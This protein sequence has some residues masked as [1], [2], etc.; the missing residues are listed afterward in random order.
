MSTPPGERRILDTG[1]SEDDG[2]ADPG[3]AAAL[4]A[5][6]RDPQRYLEVLATLQTARLLVPVVAMLGEVEYD[7]QGLAHDKTSDMASVL[8]RGNDGRLA[9]LAFTS[10]ATLQAWDPEAR[11]VPV[12]AMLAAQSAVQDGAEALLVDVAGP[13]RLVLEGQDLHAVAGGWQIAQLAGRPTWIRPSE[14]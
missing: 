4:A 13:V 3:L 6:D 2:R 10:L 12:A 5:Y 1:F 11:P 9:L 7:E 14:G 8:L